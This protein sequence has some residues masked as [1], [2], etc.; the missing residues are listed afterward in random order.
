MKWL[1]FNQFTILSGALGHLFM[2][3][4]YFA[5]E[6]WY[7]EQ[8]KCYLYDFF[9]HQFSFKNLTLRNLNVIRRCLV[10]TITACKQ[11]STQ[12]YLVVLRN[13]SDLLFDVG[14]LDA[15]FPLTHVWKYSKTPFIL[16][17]MSIKM[18]YIYVCYPNYILKHTLSKY[19]FHLEGIFT[20]L[21]GNTLSTGS[22]RWHKK[23]LQ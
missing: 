7:K 5:L 4:I 21:F 23:G 14:Y 12:S 9:L 3:Y 8:V 20:N 18:A 6:V 17:H 19:A 11:W 22:C 2:I 15:E 10:I 1:N 13:R 16:E